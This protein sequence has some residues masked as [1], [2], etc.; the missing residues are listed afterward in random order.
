MGIALSR[1]YVPDAQRLA[2][3]RTVHAQNPWLIEQVKG[4]CISHY[5][6]PPFF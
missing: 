3:I 2:I 4:F 6:T 1:K 5:L